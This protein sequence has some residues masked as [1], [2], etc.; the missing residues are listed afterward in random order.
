M[1]L[2]KRP[3]HVSV[4]L[5]AE[6]NQRPKADLDR[7]VDQAAEVATWCACAEIPM[8]SIFDKNGEL[9]VY[10]ICPLYKFPID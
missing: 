4:I 9:L 10:I 6:E 5:K 3:Q 2:G 1:A 7:M 8:V